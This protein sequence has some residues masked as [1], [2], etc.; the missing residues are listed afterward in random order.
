MSSSRSGSEDSSPPAGSGARALGSAAG[1]S[2]DAE[3]GAVTAGTLFRRAFLP[4]YPEDAAANLARARTEDANPAGNPSIL[5]H[6]ADAATI[7]AKL[8]PAALGRGRGGD[9]REHDRE[10]GHGHGHA[11]GLGREHGRDREPAHGRE[12]REHDRDPRGHEGEREHDRDPRDGDGD[13]DGDGDDLRLDFSDASV[14]RLG[15]ALDR[16]AR[17]RWLAEPS[18][19]TSESTLFNFVVHAAAYV[20]ECVVRGHGGRWLVRRPLWE[21]LVELRSAAGEAQLAVFHWWL[22]ALG[23]DALAIPPSV[24]TLGDRYRM[25]VEEPTR[26]VD[27][28]PIFLRIA[29][30]LPR[31]SKVRYDAL[32]KYLRAHLPEIVDLGLDFPSPERF[33][34]MRLRWIDAHVV[35][36]GRMALLVGAGEGGVHLFWLDATGFVK[37]AFVPADSFPEPVVRVEEGRIR[38]VVQQNGEPAM[39]EM[40]WWGL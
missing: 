8:A 7:F 31:L 3:A 9:E 27:A 25:H 6:L 39:R 35:G 19:G 1:A 32:Y 40:L 10:H 38:A 26:D 36:G 16:D 12:R 11:H 34:D 13:G 24:A 18:V 20:G 21:S 2:S 4:L 14:H 17:D 37:G 5:A 29:R 15:A 28:L 23:D 22:K 33:D 30:K